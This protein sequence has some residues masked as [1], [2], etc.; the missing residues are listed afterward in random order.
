MGL[1]CRLCEA[2]AQCD[3]CAGAAPFPTEWDT[4]GLPLPRAPRAP[5]QPSSPGLVQCGDLSKGPEERLT[6]MHPS[7]QICSSSHC[8]GVW[9]LTWGATVMGPTGTIG[10]Q[11][12]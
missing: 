2:V 5:S 12:L 7:S 10:T 4:H 3:S 11:S 9:V 8:P 1:S 6:A